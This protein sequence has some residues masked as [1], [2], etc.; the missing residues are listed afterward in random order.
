MVDSQQWLQSLPTAEGLLGKVQ[1]L[2]RQSLLQKGMP[3]ISDEDWRL[4]NLNQLKEFLS[5]PISCQ[6]SKLTELNCREWPDCSKEVF[7]L[8]VDPQLRPMDPETLPQG[9]QILNS[10]ELIQ[11]LA[12]KEN[13]QP[14]DVSWTEL[15]N[16]ASATKVLGLSV[17]GKDVPPI[18][19]IINAEPG[20]FSSTRVIFILKENAKLELVQVVLGRGNSTQSHLLEM[21]LHKGAVLNHAFLGYGS[22][23]SCLLAKLSVQQESNS[24]YCFTGIQHGWALGRL[25]PHIV[26]KEG[27]AS[28]TLRGLQITKGKEQIATHSRIR[29]E[30]PEGKLDQLQKGIA[31][32][33]SHCIF[34]GGI[35]VPRIAQQT[36]ASQLSRNLLLSKRARIDTKPELKIIADDVRCTH[37]AT[38]SQLKEEELFYLRSRGIA[39]EQAIRLLLKGYCQDVLKQ[40]PLPAKE[41]SLLKNL[42]KNVS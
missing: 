18:E 15:I 21:H 9:L 33:H 24:Q 38:V 17:E 14:S 25:E 32:D 40:L 34:N 7:R 1:L 19:L 3:S 22:G 30:G 10:K 20:K 28:T 31:A 12:L 27:E 5:L 36:N 37:G 6:D 35:E 41:W 13:S 42:L 29:F 4:T 11:A 2:G 39:F 23:Q 26:Q 16:H 8:I